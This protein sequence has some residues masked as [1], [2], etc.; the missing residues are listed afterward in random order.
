[1]ANVT[2]NSEASTILE[3]SQTLRELTCEEKL[4]LDGSSGT[5]Q[6]SE[7]S[8]TPRKLTCEEKV[9]LE[10]DSKLVTDF[11]QRK[12]ELEAGKNWDLFYKRNTTKFFKDRHWTTREFV[13]L[14]Q[15]EVLTLVILR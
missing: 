9:R 1:M 3:I 5:T 13:E 12:L 14:I 8:Q 10:K 4:R 6:T 15:R 7:L 11:R 2:S